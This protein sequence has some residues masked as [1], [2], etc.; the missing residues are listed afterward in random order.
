[1][2]VGLALVGLAVSAHGASETTDVVSQD[3]K[4]AVAS[5]ETSIK[6]RILF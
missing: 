5:L 1:M 4:K 6:T 2:F 3:V